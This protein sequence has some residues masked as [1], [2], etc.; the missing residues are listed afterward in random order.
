MPQY[1]LVV[2]KVWKLS[3]IGMG[4]ILGW[5]M[6]LFW[7]NQWAMVGLSMKRAKASAESNRS[8][9]RV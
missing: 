3:P 9:G 1:H 7:A 5:V 4:V 8:S 6:R 2:A